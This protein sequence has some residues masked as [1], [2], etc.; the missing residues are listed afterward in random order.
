[1]GFSEKRKK[2]R[3]RNRKKEFITT[4]KES[5]LNLPSEKPSKAQFNPIKDESQ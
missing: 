3:R 1:L 2:G 5:R 4:K